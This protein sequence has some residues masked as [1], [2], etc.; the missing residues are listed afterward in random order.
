MGVPKAVVSDLTVIHYQL[1]RNLEANQDLVN[2][3][4]T[5]NSLAM[6]TKAGVEARKLVV[7]VSSYGRSFKMSSARCKG[8][9]CSFTGPKS[10]AAKGKCTDTAGYI[11]NAELEA[12]IHSHSGDVEKWYDATTDSDYMIFD[13]K[14]MLNARKVS[15][16]ITLMI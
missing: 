1:Y 16:L 12:L 10:G 6:V 9:T 13:G 11:S 7:G 14:Y 15:S 2:L 4:E 8:P 5:E 3:T